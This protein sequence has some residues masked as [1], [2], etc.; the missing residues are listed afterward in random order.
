MLIANW[1]QAKG[2]EWPGWF[3]EFKVDEFIKDENCSHI[4][5][6]TGNKNK[7]EGMLD[8]DLFFGSLLFMVI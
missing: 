8:F 5:L 2:T 4:M 7:S 1:Y 3:L 6:Y